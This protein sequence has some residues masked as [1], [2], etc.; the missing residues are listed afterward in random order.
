MT[1]HVPNPLP[2][3]PRPTK[4]YHKTAYPYISPDRPELSVSGKTLFITG[5]AG[6]VGRNICRAF[7]Q[8]GIERIVI[9]GRTLTSLNEVKSELESAHP[10]TEIAVHAIDVTD[11]AALQ[12]VVR[13]TG[14]IDIVVSAAAICHPGTPTSTVE[15]AT[16]S[17]I[18]QTNTV[19]PFQVISEILHHRAIQGW[20]HELK[21]IYISTALSH[22]H[23]NHLSG[24]AASK[25]AMNLLLVHLNM[26]WNDRG[27]SLFAIHPGLIYTSMTGKV[28]PADS[29]IWEDGNLSASF[30]V[31]L[32]HPEAAFLSGKML[33]AQ[34]DV[35][36]LLAQKEWIEK[37]PWHLEPGLCLPTTE[38]P[39]QDFFT[40]DNRLKN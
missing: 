8:A 18:L 15:P 28:F 20:N 9:I 1:K 22:I 24:Y 31:W 34:W 36:E 3:L 39:S 32:C 35:Q 37:Y 38:R 27:V 26:Q 29:P 10:S 7:A 6:G 2:D 5:G 11:V 40:V 13:E 19:G 33:W 23:V 30:C 25:A 16:L 4:A 14:K 21:V 12:S 17:D